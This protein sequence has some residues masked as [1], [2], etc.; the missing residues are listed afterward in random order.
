M[1]VI[2]LMGSS[3]IIDK[4]AHEGAVLTHIDNISII[5]KCNAEWRDTD[6]RSEWMRCVG[7]QREEG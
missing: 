4:E 2:K 6:A 7:G 1:V 5:M 3:L